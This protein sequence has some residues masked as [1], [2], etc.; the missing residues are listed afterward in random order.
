MNI[1][2]LLRRKRLKGDEVGKALLLSLIY[3][4]SRSRNRAADPP[5]TKY[6]F[7]GLLEKM[8]PQEHDAYQI[9]V[10]AYNGLRE[11]I[12]YMQTMTQQINHGF[13][14]AMM[15]MQLALQYEEVQRILSSY[16]LILTQ[17]KYDQLREKALKT[18]R[19]YKASYI[20]LVI[21]GI[22][23]Y[24]GIYGNKA[25]T[26]EQLSAILEAYKEKTVTDPETLEQ[27]HEA[28]PHKDP[29]QAVTLYDLA[30][31]NYSAILE[32]FDGSTSKSQKETREQY[33]RFTTL[34]PELVRFM[35][36]D[37]DKLQIGAFK[38]IPASQKARPLVTWGELA[39]NQIYSYPDLTKLHISNLMDEYSAGDATITNPRGK[40]R[41]GIAIIQ[42]ETQLSDY[43]IVDGTYQDPSAGL[44]AIAGVEA[45][46]NDEDTSKTLDIAINAMMLQG[47]TYSFYYGMVL[48]EVADILEM[49]ELDQ[50]GPDNYLD[51]MTTQIEA[52]NGIAKNLEYRQIDLD[53]EKEE[54]KKEMVRE[55]FPQI[56]LDAWR[57]SE[58]IRAT[59]HH[60]MQEG[61]QYVFST[62]AVYISDLIEDDAKIFKDRG[63]LD[64]ESTPQ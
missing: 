18:V 13:Y 59:A 41:N 63:E 43:N 57:P 58:Q 3:D 10:D 30:A 56:N 45:M 38:R 19:S 34:M 52:Y 64:D 42:P 61:K 6:E 50:L 11:C 4:N 51:Q 12:N 31:G 53:D 14:R 33:Q 16:P 22:Y 37:I 47:F 17:Q 2:Q 5:F 46:Y 36:N 54:R 60:V 7:M 48:E 29:E 40:S 39:D 49:P 23:F 25:E 15:Y 9:Y 28:F 35:E 32:M 62:L 27:L 20:S 1:K 24:T 55:L 44:L 26:P 8:P 21:A